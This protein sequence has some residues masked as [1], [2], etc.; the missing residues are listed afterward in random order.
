MTPNLRSFLF[1]PQADI[2]A[3]ELAVCLKEIDGAINKWAR[4]WLDP[5]AV[6]RECVGIMR[7]FLP[8]GVNFGPEED[9]A[10]PETE[11]T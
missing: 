10:F 8:H 9:P 4:I 6:E 5:E 11:D 2:T 7:H 3:Y 1:E